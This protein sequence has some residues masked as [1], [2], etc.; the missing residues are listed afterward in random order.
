MFPCVVAALDASDK[1]YAPASCPEDTVEMLRLPEAPDP[2]VGDPVGIPLVRVPTV[3]KL[4]PVVELFS[5][6]AYWI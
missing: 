2:N 1:L 5:K 4:Q 6:S 3:P